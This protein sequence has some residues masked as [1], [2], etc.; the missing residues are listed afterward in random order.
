MK[1]VKQKSFGY[2]VLRD[3]NDDYVR[4]KF[5]STIE[6]HRVQQNDQEV[7]I[8]C[9]FKAGP[10]ELSE[11]VDAGKASYILV[12]DCR[13]T[14]YRESFLINESEKDLTCPKSLF[15][16]RVVVESYIIANEKIS[17]FA[18][19]FIN[20]DYGK[21]PF[22]F[23]KYSVL[24]QRVPEIYF[25]LNDKLKSLQSLLKLEESKLPDGEWYCDL[26]HPDGHPR[27]MASPHQCRIFKHAAASQE[28]E[29]ML[30]NIVLVPAVA[31]MIDALNKGKEMETHDERWV[32]LLQEKLQ[33][34]NLAST[35]Y[36]DSFRLAQRLLGLP[37]NRI[38]HK[39]YD[40][41]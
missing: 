11:L 35:A 38:K 14:F 20:E 27:I 37:L 18:C 34:K 25:V 40:G 23:E 3:G 8:S 15:R 41:D 28:S 5:Q 21:G 1:F 16:G 4:G 31:K 30:V 26:G 10:P 36:D 33:E 13:E 17:N 22:T 39:L 7:K 19:E 2:P 24:A 32:E 29:S 9:I 12:I 6:F